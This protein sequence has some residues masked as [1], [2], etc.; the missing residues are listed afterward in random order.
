MALHYITYVTLALLVVD[1]LV[2]I[3]TR[4]R[5]YQGERRQR[6]ALWLAQR[7]R[8]QEEFWQQTAQEANDRTAAALGRVM[9]VA[10]RAVTLEASHARLQLAEARRQ[11]RPEDAV[12]TEAPEGF[13]TAP[14]ISRHA[15]TAPL[16]SFLDDAA[17]RNPD[18][19]ITRVAEELATAVANDLL[20]SGALHVTAFYEAEQKALIVEAALSVQ[21]PE[22]GAP[23]V[24]DAIRS[25]V[26]TLDR[27]GSEAPTS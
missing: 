9:D 25:A 6:G 16:S 19:L 26:P 11:R 27:I 21:R 18:V 22:P 2:H 14:A 8:T 20:R 10:R 3:S 17:V 13:Q 12:A 5:Y 15:V 23:T 1:I 4:A 24:A 7:A